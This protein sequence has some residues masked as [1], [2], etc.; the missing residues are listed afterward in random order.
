MDPVSHLIIGLGT[1]AL[2]GQPMA[3]TNPI[4]I[5]AA[6]G[7]IA[8]DLDVATHFNPFTFLKHHRGITHSIPGLVGISFIITALLAAFFPGGNYLSYFAWTFLGALSHSVLD[9]FNSYGTHLLWPFK[10]QKWSANLLVLCDPWLVLFYALLLFSLSGPGLVSR[11]IL[12]LVAFYIALRYFMRQKLMRH[13]KSTFGLAESETLVVMPG[14]FFANW[15]FVIEKERQFILGRINYY[16][17]HISEEMA[18]EKQLPNPFMERALNSRLGQFF[19][20]FTPYLHLEYKK[21]QEEHVVFFRDL[22]FM[23]KN[24]TFLHTATVTVNDELKI[25]SSYL[26]PFSKDNR[27]PMESD[28]GLSHVNSV[29]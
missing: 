12:L 15:D 27:V 6:L 13:I 10:K 16:S 14:N 17:L 20:F 21:E 8:P 11:V 3:V 1:A 2:S 19:R 7:A 26:H 25:I 18:L 5:G 22:R 24:S 4:Y 9:S 28:M 23:L 29:K